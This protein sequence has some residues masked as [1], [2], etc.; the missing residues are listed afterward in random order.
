MCVYIYNIKF[1]TIL[2]HANSEA[3]FYSS[4]D[5]VKLTIGNM[6]VVAIYIHEDTETTTT[7]PHTDTETNTTKYHKMEKYC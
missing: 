4:I 5:H 3:P 6:A 7:K 1:F 2:Y